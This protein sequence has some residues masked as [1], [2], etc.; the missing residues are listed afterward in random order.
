MKTTIVGLGLIGGSLARDLR[1]LGLSKEIWGVD[2]N[3]AHQKEALRMGLVDRIVDLAE[4][5]SADLVIIATPVHTILGILKS[6]LDHAP[7]TSTIIDMGS[8]KAEICGAI[9]THPK[10]HQYVASHPMAGTEN[11]GPQAAIDGLFEGRTTVICDAERSG[12]DA[13][14]RV[15]DLYRQLHMR[16]V[17]MNAS[18]HDLHAAFVSHLSHISS[19]VLANTVLAQEKNTRTIFDLAGGG[20]ESTVR[21]AK[22]SPVM[23]RAIF[24][25]NQKHVQTALKM[26]IDELHKFYELLSQGDGPAL[27]D[28]MN[29][30]NAIRAVLS[31]MANNVAVQMA[32]SVAG[33]KSK[34]SS[35]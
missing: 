30:A 10:R 27:E 1:R 35:S 4:G 3:E 25:Q 7:A 6:V 16:V 32:S 24:E 13:L 15:E 9:A 29:E 33:S 23:W 21:L 2:N 5:A 28:K 8:T 20:F 18:D 31:N 34:G 12:P 19:F 26:Y 22:S 17:Y 14:R 11:S